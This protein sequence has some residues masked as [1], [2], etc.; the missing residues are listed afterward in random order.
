MTD[1][2]PKHQPTA[3]SPAQSFDPIAEVYDR[4][5]ELTGQPLLELLSNLLPEHGDSALNLSGLP[6]EDLDEHLVLLRRGKP[7]ARLG[8]RL[9]LLLGLWHFQPP[10][11]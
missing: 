10:E 11:R 1:D 8:S 7:P 6:G 5:M 9:R 4:L 3:A 2:T